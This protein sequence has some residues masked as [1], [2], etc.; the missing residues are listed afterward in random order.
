MSALIDRHVLRDQ[1]ESMQR[2]VAKD[3]PRESATGK[4]I[5]LFFD[6]VYRLIN[7]MADTH[8]EQNYT[9]HMTKA[10]DPESHWVR[11]RKEE[12]PVCNK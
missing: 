3:I 4:L 7:K 5:T 8:P 1:L 9:G 11:V 12:C 2:D 6:N 10:D